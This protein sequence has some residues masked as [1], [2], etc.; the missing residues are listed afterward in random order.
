MTLLCFIC[1]L[2][3]LI[4]YINTSQSEKKNIF[5]HIYDLMRKFE[6]LGSE[7]SYPHQVLLQIHAQLDLEVM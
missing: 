1:F 6:L 4:L 7:I 3:P 5:Y 2:L